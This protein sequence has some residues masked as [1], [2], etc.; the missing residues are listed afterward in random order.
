[1]DD[2]VLVAL[3]AT[4]ASSRAAFAARSRGFLEEATPVP[5]V[6]QTLADERG[7]EDILRRARDRRRLRK[8]L[9]GLRQIAIEKDEVRRR[10]RG[11]SVVEGGGEAGRLERGKDGERSFEVTAEVERGGAGDARREADRPE[12]AEPRALEARRR[13]LRSRMLASREEARRLPDPP[14]LAKNADPERE[15][16]DDRDPGGGGLLE[17]T[18]RVAQDL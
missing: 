10:G 1:V 18:R 14:G 3:L 9:G 7:E 12:D 15:P 8:Q 4:G 2:R 6:A 5:F 16:G 17:Q 11:R 13:A